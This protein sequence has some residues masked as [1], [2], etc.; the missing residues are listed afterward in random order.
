MT[1]YDKEGN[2]KIPYKEDSTK[3]SSLIQPITYKG[4]MLTQA[5]I[6]SRVIATLVNWME[7]N[8]IYP[9]TMSEVARRPL[10]MLVE[11]L[12][13]NGEVQMIECSLKDLF[14]TGVIGTPFSRAMI[15]A[16]NCALA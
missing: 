5:W 6:D 8:E 7:K 2:R 14:H 10:E 3:G 16:D 12:V 4:D 9:R 11:S 13:K 1:Y 15:K